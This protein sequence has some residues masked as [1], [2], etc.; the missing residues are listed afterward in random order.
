MKLIVKTLLV[1]GLTMFLFLSLLYFIIRPFL[2]DDSIKLDHSVTLENLERINNHFYSEMEYLNSLNRDWA[3]WDDTYLFM[4]KEY[5][6]YPDVNLND[7]TFENN[8][9]NF[10]VYIN[11]QNKMIYQKGYDL[12][13]HK[14]VVLDPNFYQVF[15]S[16]LE[17]GEEI[18]NSLLIL[19]DYGLTITS[20]QS[21]YK[22]NGEGPIAGTLIMG[23]FIN[24]SY[25]ADIGKELSLPISLSRTNNNSLPSLFK[26]DIISNLKL[27]GSLFLQD[28]LGKEAFKISFISDRKF[29]LQKISSMKVLYAY[30]LITSVIF[31]IL[32]IVL[33]NRFVLSRVRLLSSQLTLIQDNKDIKSRIKISNGHKDEITNLENSINRA[34]SALEDK[35]NEV[36]KLAYFDQ[37]TLLPNRYLLFQEFER[38]K[39]QVSEEIA[40]L[41]VD[42]DGFKRINDSLGHKVGDELLKIVCERVQPIIIEKEGIMAR[43]GGDEFV[44]L[45]KYTDKTDLENVIQKIIFEIGKEYQIDRYKT[46]VTASIGVSIYR[47][48]GIT[49]AQ[50]LQNADIAMYEAKRSGKNQSHFF[51]DLNNNSSYKQFLELE[52]DLLYALKQNQFELYYQII[53]NGSSRQVVGVEALLRW[54]HPTKGMIS[55]AKFIPIAEEIGLMPAI[56]QWVLEEAI[57]QMEEWHRKG[58]NHLTLAI[59]LSKS[60]MKDQSFIEKLDQVLLESNFPASK[61]QLEITE[62]NINNYLKE[63]IEF[64]KELKK[65][66]V[67]IA[68]DDF[69][70]GTSS[71]QYLKELS[72]DI[73]KIDRNFIENVPTQSFDTLLLSGIFEIIKGLDLEVVV[74]GIERLEQLEFVTAHIHSNLQGF[75]FSKPLPSVELETILLKEDQFQPVAHRK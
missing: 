59:N 18:N 22:S 12:Q 3:V 64:M 62:S 36:V 39:Q 54:K 30:L 5:R 58:M 33:L 15:L 68:L 14:P 29:Y 53:V 10:I 49:L 55:P 44:L 25:I 61:L 13:H 17:Q 71:L 73:I 45:I 11:K 40:I 43:L 69:G 2:L 47:K 51:A 35:H 63:V 28:Y 56:G 70:V 57:K 50:L 38:Y 8:Y 16:I 74:E 60:Q 27:S 4:S 42:L 23:K 20:L 52:N 9:I 75:Y 21:I 31:V 65:R 24:E 7:D 48:D 72:I 66:N 46:F 34:L 67:C 32:T 6:S 26:V 1:V 37:L 19:T 41:F